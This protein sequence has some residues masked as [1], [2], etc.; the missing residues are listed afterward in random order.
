ML[1]QLNILCQP[2]LPASSGRGPPSVMMGFGI[3]VQLDALAS[4]MGLLCEQ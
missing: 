4:R 3:S 1:M 2:A